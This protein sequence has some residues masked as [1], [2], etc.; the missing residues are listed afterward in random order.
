MRR[1]P[2]ILLLCAA[3]AGGSIDEADDDLT[4][5][6]TIG[7]QSLTRGT[8]TSSRPSLA[9]AFN[10][11]AGDTVAPDAWPPGQSALTPTLAL[12]GP[13]GR[14]GHRPLLATGA[15]R[16]PDP[17]HPAIDG[18]RLPQTGNYLIVVGTVAGGSGGKFALRLW[19]ASSHLP[20][21]E[22]S[23]VALDL[24][25]SAAA[26]TVVQSHA[27]SP[28]AWTDGEVDGLIA[29]LNQQIDPRVA[30]SSAQYLLS[31]LQQQ[32]ATDAQRGRARTAVAQLIGTPAHFSTLGPEIQAFAL[33]WLGN[34][35]SLLFTT[36]GRA[37]PDAVGETIGHLVAAW[38]G[39][40]EETAN[41]RV[42]AKTLNGAVYGW[43]AEWQADWID[44]DGR[45]VWIDYAREWFDASG[46]WLREQSPGASEPDDE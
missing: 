39:A 26:V 34:G 2:S 33:W 7:P 3:C 44:S 6:S 24:T 16:G 12:L 36:E 27:D 43:Q 38:P 23:Q 17:R 30:L 29:D 31:A 41:R 35:E 46:N 15:P 4:V 22:T 21:Q 25:P 13:K 28:H 11:K 10:G 1:F 14:N 9:Y 19:M 32:N 37:A 8:L 45:P 20:R 18:V 42:A 40:K 5:V